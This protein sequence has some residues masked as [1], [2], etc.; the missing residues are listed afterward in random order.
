MNVAFIFE[1]IGLKNLKL[2]RQSGT[3]RQIFLMFRQID[4]DPGRIIFSFSRSL[5]FRW[6]LFEQLD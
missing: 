3:G 4:P 5:I 1:K 6:Q 2:H